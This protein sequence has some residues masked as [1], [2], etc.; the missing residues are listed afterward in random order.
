MH[1]L[2]RTVDPTLIGVGKFPLLLMYLFDI[3]LIL[4]LWFN[5]EHKG[6]MTGVFN[7][8][9]KNTLKQKVQ[10]PSRTFLKQTENT[11]NQESEYLA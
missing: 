1:L 11:K 3:L 2:L 9:N 10:A 5:Y 6:Q 8:T 7:D 4:Q